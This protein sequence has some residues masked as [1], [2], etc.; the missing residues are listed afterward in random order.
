VQQNQIILIRTNKKKDA[1]IIKNNP[2]KLGISKN[3]L[4]LRSNDVPLISE[5]NPQR[6]GGEFQK[7]PNKA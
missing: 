1:L 6:T 7:I 5:Q 3:P 2:V 4:K